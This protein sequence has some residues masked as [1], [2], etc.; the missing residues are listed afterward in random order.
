VSIPPLS[1]FIVIESLVS[2]P[3]AP[4]RAKDECALS[5]RVSPNL[6]KD[7]DLV[8]ETLNVGLG[9]LLREGF[10]LV[11]Q[12]HPAIGDDVA[13]RVADEVTQMRSFVRTGRIL[14]SNNVEGQGGA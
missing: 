10:L 4:K 3:P 2:T 1:P 5:L 6:R 7:I 11:C 14:P 13:K 9:A 8:R 12:Q